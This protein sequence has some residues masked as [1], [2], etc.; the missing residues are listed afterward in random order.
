[1]NE[2]EAG[3][4]EKPGPMEAVRAADVIRERF[5]FRRVCIH[6]KDF[7]ASAIDGIILPDDEVEAMAFGSGVAASVMGAGEVRP[8]PPDAGIKPEGRRAVDAF[9]SAGAR[10]SGTGAFISQGDLALC[11]A[12]SVY[13]PRPEVTVGLGDTLTAATFFMELQKGVRI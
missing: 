11:I 10:E 12:P 6:T 13:V 4:K 5:G 2:S 7:I 1:M 8:A 3:L 9:I